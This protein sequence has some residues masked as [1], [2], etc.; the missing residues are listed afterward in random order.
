MRPPSRLT[1]EQTVTNNDIINPN[2]IKPRSSKRFMNWRTRHVALTV[3]EQ[4]YIRYVEKILIH[5]H[6]PIQQ[7]AIVCRSILLRFLHTGTHPPEILRPK[8]ARVTRL[9]LRTAMFINGL[10]RELYLL[11][12]YNQLPGRGFPGLGQKIH[13][14][15]DSFS[16]S[17]AMHFT[18][19]TK[20]QLQQLFLHLRLPRFI[21]LTKNRA[22]FTGEETFLISL[23]KFRTGNSY[24]DLKAIFGGNPD[25]FGTVCHYFVLHVH[26]LFF[27]K[28]SGDSLRREWLPHVDSFRRLMHRRA[29][30][31]L[32]QE[33]LFLQGVTDSMDAIVIE[34]H[35]WRIWSLLDATTEETCRPH[36]GPLRPGL[37]SERRDGDIQR[38]FYSRY[39]REHGLK[40]LTLC[41]PNGMYGTVY[42]TS[43]AHNDTGIVNMCGLVDYL[44]EILENI[45]GTDTLPQT[46]GDNIFVICQVVTNATGFSDETIVERL[47]SMRESIEH[48]YNHVFGLWNIMHNKRMLKLGDDGEFLVRMNYVLFFL[49]NCYTCLTGGN[50]VSSQFEGLEEFV[51]TLEE[52]IPLDE[53]L[54]RYVPLRENDN[55]DYDFVTVEY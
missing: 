54:E 21:R 9:I 17:D 16:E 48:S 8:I 35:L 33:E 1:P 38:A 30:C 51:P 24:V 43:L 29:E 23:V 32:T 41:L 52:Y 25:F 18:R 28:I 31:S 42:G 49:T 7:R 40:F 53:E 22:K 2:T 3:P 34:E 46:L 50:I 39:Y 55:Y 27:H 19:L 5:Q 36:Q 10:S 44:H 45:P 4:S 26:D 12:S 13:R 11:Q 6:L 15:I 14:T 47:K 20:S 37:G